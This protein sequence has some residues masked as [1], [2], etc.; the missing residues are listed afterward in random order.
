[1][2]VDKASPDPTKQSLILTKKSI[3]RV[4]L[5]GPGHYNV[6]KLSGVQSIDK[7]KGSSMFMSKVERVN[8]RSEGW[9]FHKWA[10]TV[11]SAFVEAAR[12]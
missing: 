4:P 1:M 8:Y 11:V 3:E 6:E 2:I 7:L 5:P 12:K 9:K 10:N